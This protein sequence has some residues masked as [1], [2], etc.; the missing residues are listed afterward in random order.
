[1]ACECRAR[2]VLRS[3]ENVSLAQGLLYLLHLMFSAAARAAL[4]RHSVCRARGFAT[5]SVAVDG[6]TGAIGSTPLVRLPLF[7]SLGFL[8]KQLRF[9]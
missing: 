8:S 4:V 2:L 6:F 3:P 1:M 7:F 9:F 5:D